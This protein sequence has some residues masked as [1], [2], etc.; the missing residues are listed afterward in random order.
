[1]QTSNEPAKILVEDD[2]PEV[3]GF[4]SV[5]LKKQNYLFDEVED[6]EQ[7]LEKIQK[8]AP[9]VVLLDILTPNLTDDE[10]VKMITIWKP[11][12][13]VIMTT[14]LS[15]QEIKSECLKMSTLLVDINQSI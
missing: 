12:I 13:L 8:F 5:Y 10:L 6:G 3:R 9:D 2:Y 11:N 15:D 1:M 7:A 14:A 4:L